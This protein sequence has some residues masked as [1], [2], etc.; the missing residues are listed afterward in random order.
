MTIAGESTYNTCCG[1]IVTLIVSIIVIIFAGLAI[2]DLVNYDG[3]SYER[4]LI[5]SAIDID[6]VFS[7]DDT[8][9]ALA[10]GLVD[11]N[12]R[13]GKMPSA[14]E[15][16]RYFKFSARATT[17]ALE[18]VNDESDALK[19]DLG[20]HLCTDEDKTYFYELTDLNTAGVEKIWDQLFC[21]D[22]P[23]SLKF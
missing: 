20:L 3:S 21:I 16:E 19:V 7:F 18:D 13:L 23:A 11:K 22:D 17:R 14:S 10:I 8:H 5:T 1:L 12:K 6:Q 2:L 15:L 4:K 9:F